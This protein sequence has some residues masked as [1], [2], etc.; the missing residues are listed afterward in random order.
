MY[1]N[2]CMAVMILS[3]TILSGPV[4]DSGWR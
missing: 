2:A 4:K 3:A 1:A